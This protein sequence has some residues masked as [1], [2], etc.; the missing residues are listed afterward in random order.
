MPRVHRIMGRVYLVSVAIGG[1]AALVMAPF[2]T[3]GFVGFF[4]FGSLGV[5]WLVTGWKAYRSDPGR[6]CARRI[7]PG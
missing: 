6:R 2:N 3:A 1:P 7:R 5:L 4:G